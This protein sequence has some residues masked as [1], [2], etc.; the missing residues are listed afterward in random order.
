MCILLLGE[1]CINLNYVESV[2]GAFQVYYIF[3]LFCMFILLI[4]E[5]LMLKLQQKVL[6][7]LLKKI[8]VYKV[9][10]CVTFSVFSKSS[11]NVL[12][13]FHNLKI[14]KEEKNKRIALGIIP[15]LS[16]F[17]NLLRFYPLPWYL[18]LAFDTK[19]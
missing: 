15:F 3:L 18:I 12:S 17:H 11:V 14:K 13:Y 19:L 1:N 16:I 8:I 10:L 7:H 5:S 6:I 2:H 4:F 9:E